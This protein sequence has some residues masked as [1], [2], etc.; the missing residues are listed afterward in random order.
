MTRY[1][2][3]TCHLVLVESDLLHPVTSDGPICPVCKHDYN[4]RPMC[5]EDHIHCP[6]VLV[7]GIKYC[8]SCGEPVCPTCGSHD[9]I[10]LSRVTGYLQEVSGWN[11]GKLQELKDRTRYNPITGGP[12]DV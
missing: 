8:P 2:C 9:V 12:A 5:K 1:K 7:A 3:H 4:L 6:H 11:A 10:Q